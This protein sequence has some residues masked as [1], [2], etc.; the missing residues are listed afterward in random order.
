MKD[1]AGLDYKYIEFYKPVTELNELFGVFYCRIDNTSLVD[2]PYLKYLG[3]L[4][5]RQDDG[6]L[7]FPHGVWEGWY[8]SEELKFAKD[9]GYKVEVFKGYLFLML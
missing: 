7:I 9:N 6:S 3:L 1:L 8:F 2:H 4:P 5:H